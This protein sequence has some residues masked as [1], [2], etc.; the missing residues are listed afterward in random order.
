MP[1]PDILWESEWSKEY[2]VGCRM[3]M[4]M[5]AFRYGRLQEGNYKKYDLVKEI[6]RR[7]ERYEESEN[8]EF[9]LDCGNM[10]MLQFMKGKENG[11]TVKSVD[12]GEHA[13]VN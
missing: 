10:C 3:R 5:G 2:E 8:L 6:K 11:Q 4:V 9:L 12:D 13:S 7:L 1:S